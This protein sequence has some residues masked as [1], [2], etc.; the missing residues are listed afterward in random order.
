MHAGGSPN[1]IPPPGT[2]IGITTLTTPSP[3]SSSGTSTSNSNNNNNNGNNSN[4]ANVNL[5]NNNVNEIANEIIVAVQEIQTEVSKLVRMYSA[6][7]D[8][9]KA[10]LQDNQDFMNYIISNTR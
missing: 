3:S 5:L 7:S 1:L 9:H 4:A 8:K 10:A 6:D 2:N